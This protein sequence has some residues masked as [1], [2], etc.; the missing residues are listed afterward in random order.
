[1]RQRSPS[2]PPLVRLLSSPAGMLLLLLAAP[3]DSLEFLEAAIVRE[4]VF[5]GWI[6]CCWVFEYGQLS[7]MTYA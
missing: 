3:L 2:E 6:V 1:M 7:V 5:Y 4:V